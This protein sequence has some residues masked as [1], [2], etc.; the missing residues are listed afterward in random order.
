MM[1]IGQ[2]VIERFA[3]L[4]AHA[5]TEN[6]EPHAVSGQFGCHIAQGENAHPVEPLRLQQGPILSLSL[7]RSGQQEHSGQEPNAP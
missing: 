5:A 6:A 4:M 7:S 1:R 3:F 2:V